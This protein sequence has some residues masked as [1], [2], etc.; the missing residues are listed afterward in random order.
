MY[1]RVPALI[2]EALCQISAR[3]SFFFPPPL[4]LVYEMKWREKA[5]LRK[6][7]ESEQPL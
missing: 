2:P 4:D 7:K 6:E 5:K 3:A 1:V